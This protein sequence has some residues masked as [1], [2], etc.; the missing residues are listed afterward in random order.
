MSYLMEG[1]R[2]QHPLHLEAEEIKCVTALV[3]VERAEAIPARFGVV[4]KAFD[5]LL[6]HIGIGLTLL[7]ELPAPVETGL[8]HRKFALLVHRS[9]QRPIVVR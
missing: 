4:E 7:E 9:Q 5:E 2:R 3:R 1:E 6:H 8:N